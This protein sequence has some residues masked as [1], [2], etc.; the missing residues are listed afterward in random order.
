MQPVKTTTRKP[1]NAY[2]FYRKLAFFTQAKIVKISGRKPTIS[3]TLSPFALEVRL[4]MRKLDSF[5]LEPRVRRSLA[6]PSSSRLKIPSM[7]DCFSRPY[8]EHLHV[9]ESRSDREIKSPVGP[10]GLA[11]HDALDPLRSTHNTKVDASVFFSNRPVWVRPLT[12]VSHPRIEQTQGQ[13][14][15][16]PARKCRDRSPRRFVKN[17]A[18]NDRW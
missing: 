9:G 15:R 8:Y 2:R 13:N 14:P 11:F 16:K 10:R 18:A 4:S 5:G 6:A 7:S 12:P 3:N 17:D 1:P